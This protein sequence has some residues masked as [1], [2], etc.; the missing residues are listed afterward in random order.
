MQHEQI[1]ADL[2]SGRIGLAQNRLPVTSHIEDAAP[3]EL[4]ARHRAL[5]LQALA[6][7]RVAVVTLAGG[8]RIDLFE[9]S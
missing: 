7:G 8:D 5:G 4:D 9:K 2:H 3:D 1:Q 6:E